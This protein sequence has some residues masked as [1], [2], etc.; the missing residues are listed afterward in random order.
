MFNIIV[1][2]GSSRKG[3]LEEREN[4]QNKAFILINHLTMLEIILQTLQSVR[5][6]DKIVVVGPADQL[7]KLQKKSHHFEIVDEQD[8]HLNN[9]AAGLKTV[10]PHKPCVVVSADIPLLTKEAFEDFLSRCF[11]YERDFYYPVIS[12]EECEKQFPDAKRTFVRL[13]EGA[14]TG[15][16]IMM[17]K[18][19]WLLNK[20]DD[21]NIYLSYRKRPWKLVQ[22]LPF[23]LIVKFIFRRL[24]FKDMEEYVFR[25]MGIK[26]KVVVTPYVEIGVDVDKPEDLD[27]IK[28][29]IG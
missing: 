15:G 9:I 25:L 14:F 27:L 19:Y 24:T 4:V 7:A 20:I 17:L 28:G 11:P 1:L 21:I 26:A 16:N 18:P 6:I 12:R 10:E 29:I 2:A 3:E 23:S 5:E 22:T 8:T 13:E